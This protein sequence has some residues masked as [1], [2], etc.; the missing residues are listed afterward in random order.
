MNHTQKNK[1]IQKEE[2]ALKALMYYEILE[3][4]IINSDE[5]KT[6]RMFSYDHD[7]LL[8]WLKDNKDKNERIKK[9]LEDIRKK[10]N[11]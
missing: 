4:M 5:G 8:K 3:N 1:L 11:K 9:E 6:P 2:Q 10:L 7:G